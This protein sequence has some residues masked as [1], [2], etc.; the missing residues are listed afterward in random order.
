VP[1]LFSSDLTALP[2]IA[3]WYAERGLQ[4]WV[5]LPERLLPVRSEGVEPNRVLTVELSG[6]AGAELPSRPDARWLQIGAQDVPVDVLS[7]VVDGDVA[8]TTVA[9]AAIG[10]GAVTTAPDG[11]VWAGLSDVTVLEPERRRGLGRA[12]CAELLAWAAGR[13]A[14]HAYVRVADDNVPAIALAES[15]GFRLHHRSRYVL[16]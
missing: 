7:A 11:R 9:D 16:L 10:R 8:F 1:L 14:T 3:G 13:G 4:P 5:A 2:A 6:G 15:L 12:V